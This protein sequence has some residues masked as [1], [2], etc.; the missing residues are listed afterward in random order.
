ML[1]VLFLLEAAMDSSGSTTE[2]TSWYQTRGSPGVGG[3]ILPHAAVTHQAH[4]LP[5]SLW[6]RQVLA[7]LAELQLMVQGV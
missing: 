7:G 3:S 4:L 5:S 6:S 2:G 1:S